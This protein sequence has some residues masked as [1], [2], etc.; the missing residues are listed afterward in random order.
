MNRAAIQPAALREMHAVG[1]LY[2]HAK[3]L[4]AE[5]GFDLVERA[6]A[7]APTA[8]SP[9]PFTGDARRARRR[10]QGRAYPLRA[11][12]QFVDRASGE[13]AAAADQTLR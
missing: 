1:R 5:I 9:P 2:E 10:R 3:T 11:A 8:I 12:L 6:P 13:A 7:A 4:A